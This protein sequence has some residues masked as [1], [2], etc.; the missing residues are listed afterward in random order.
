MKN[1]KG[2]LN[3]RATGPKSA[4]GPGR[5]RPSRPGSHG[6][7][8]AQHGPMA[9]SRGP[10]ASEA[11]PR[12]A[13]A[14]RSGAHAGALS[15]RSTPDGAH[16][17]FHRGMTG[18]ERPTAGCQEGAPPRYRDYPTHR[19]GKKWRAV[20]H[21]NRTVTRWQISPVHGGGVRRLWWSGKSATPQEASLRWVGALGPAHNDGRGVRQ[22][23]T[24]GAAE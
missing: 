7:R 22:L 2:I 23:G 6:A 13:L 12:A 14:Q 1:R 10:Q 17:A 3:S 4:R 24:D 15:A 21:R 9:C 20:G 16:T 18:S 19:P 8:P 11:G 5:Q